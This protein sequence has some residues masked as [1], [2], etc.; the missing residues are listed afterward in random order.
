MRTEKAELYLDGAPDLLPGR[1]TLNPDKTQIVPLITPGNGI[2][3]PPSR[4][5]RERVLAHPHPYDRVDAIIYSTEELAAAGF[6]GVDT[7]HALFAFQ[8]GQAELVPERRNPDR[9]TSETAAELGMALNTEDTDSQH[10]KDVNGAKA[11]LERHMEELAAN[12]LRE[13]KG[14]MA[15]VLPQS[16]EVGDDEIGKV[17]DGVKQALIYSSPLRD[18]ITKGGV[19]EFLRGSVTR[20]GEKAL[21][22]FNHDDDFRWEACVD[23][24]FNYGGPGGSV[25]ISRYFRCSD[26]VRDDLLAVAPKTIQLDDNSK[27]TVTLEVRRADDRGPLSFILKHESGESIAT[28]VHNRRPPSTGRG[29]GHER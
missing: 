13:Y 26:R 16:P 20:A 22:D 9:V 27:H 29:G 14:R 28:R 10:Q 24:A 6:T 3:N 1:P 23:G 12:I 2:S 17:F 19:A 7:P 11:R 25:D 18:Q 8:Y 4:V 5:N 21:A 15:K